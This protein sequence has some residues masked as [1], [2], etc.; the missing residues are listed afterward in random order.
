MVREH[1]Q[2][3]IRALGQPKLNILTWLK[4]QNLS[5]KFGEFKNFNREVRNFDGARRIFYEVE[6]HMFIRHIFKTIWPIK[7][8]SDVPKSSSKYHFWGENLPNKFAKVT[9]R[10][11]WLIG[12]EEMNIGMIFYTHAQIQ[13]LVLPKIVRKI[14]IFS[15]NHETIRV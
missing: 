2:V 8:C 12:S 14:C 11:F 15:W 6:W 9:S 1:F 5:T 13:I 7:I 4:V 10:L 3:P